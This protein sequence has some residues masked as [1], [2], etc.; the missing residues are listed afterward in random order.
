MHAHSCKAQK[1]R[2]PFQ[3]DIGFLAQ[4]LFQCLPESLA[5]LHTAARQ[6]PAGNISVLHKKDRIFLLIKNDRPNTK[7]HGPPKQKYV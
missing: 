7:G 2:W 4:F 1:L 5:A 6:L 3:N